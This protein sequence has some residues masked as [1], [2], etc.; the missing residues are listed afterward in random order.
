MYPLRGTV[1]HYSWGSHTALAELTGRPAP[2]QEPEAELWLGAHPV[3]P[4]TVDTGDAAVPLCDLI[5]RDPEGQLGPDCA[6]QFDGR[7]PF[8]LKV[9]AAEQPLSLQAHPSRAQAREG[10]ARENAAGIPLDAPHRNYRDDNHKPEMVVA[11]SRFEALA[12]FRAPAETVEF[13]RDLRVSELTPYASEL[14]DNLDATGLRALFTAWMTLPTK[15]LVGLTDAVLSGC[16]RYL[17]DR[18]GSEDEFTAAARTA[19]ELGLAYPEDPGVLASLLLNRVSM[20]PGDALFL[21]AGNLHAYLRGTAV[22]IMANS[23]NVLRGG[24][25]SKHVDI[26]ELLRVLDFDSVGVSWVRA[27]RDGHERVYAPPVREFELWRVALDESGTSGPATTRIG[28]STP[29]ILLCVQG[30]VQLRCGHRV[31]NLQRGEAAWA[32]ASD[33]EFVVQAA[34]SDATVFVATPPARTWSV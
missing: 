23:D 14:G 26:P 1:R 12:G 28:G 22:E 7:L 17:Q 8:L 34:S 32:A 24:L 11:L 21:P 4:A 6:R 30:T 20:E 19:L 15:S 13:L 25:T 16:E 33:P 31:L 18:S 27:R 2:T 9:L 29:R 3:A 5:A 10:F